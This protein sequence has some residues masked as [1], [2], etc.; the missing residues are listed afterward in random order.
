MDKIITVLTP[1]Y[2]RGHLL[3][4]C[5]ESLIAQ[6][7]KKFLWLIVDD[8]SIDNTRELVEHWIN[9]DSINIK[10]VYKK[11]GGKHTALNIGFKMIETELTFIVDSDDILSKDAIEIIQN[12]WYKLKKESLAGISY[13]RGYNF[14]K[15]IGDKF[16][17][18]Y[19]E[20]NAIDIQFRYKIKG[21]KAEVW[22]TDILK[23]YKF[24]EYPDEK[25]QGEN[26]I[27]WQIALLYNLIYINKIIYVT[28]YHEG[29]LTRSGRKLRIKS[30]CGGMDNSKKGLHKKFPLRERI[31]R[32]IL[33]NCYRCFANKSLWF[34]LKNSD[35]HSFL[36]LVTVVP[37]WILY[38]YWNKKYMGGD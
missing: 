15:I 16:P 31:K 7:E 33:Y 3:Y 9:K 30:A 27:W 6:T 10:Y 22:R 13:L 1:T 12:D 23:Q 19:K 14:N 35:N 38:K 26:Y 4:R 36:V 25:F 21:D 17:N 28:E 18:D 24:P 5:Y 34:G 29:G 2:N 11:N 37:G 32:G 8:G 20:Y